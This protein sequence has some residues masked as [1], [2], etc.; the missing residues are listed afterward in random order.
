MIMSRK[1]TEN[2]GDFIGCRGTMR[3]LGCG[4]SMGALSGANRCQ[5]VVGYF[6]E[7]ADFLLSTFPEAPALTQGEG[8]EGGLQ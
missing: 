3:V 1:S 6:L 7:Y 5:D 2:T 4:A 8:F